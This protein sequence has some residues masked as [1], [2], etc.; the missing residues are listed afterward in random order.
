MMLDYDQSPPSPEL[1][2]LAR[3]SEAVGESMPSL[4]NER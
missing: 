3:G 4:Q 2:S 1:E